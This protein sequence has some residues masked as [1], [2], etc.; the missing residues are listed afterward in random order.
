MSRNPKALA[1]TVAALLSLGACHDQ[2]TIEGTS[3]RFINVDGKRMKVNLSPTGVPNEYQLLTVRDAMVLNPDP[4]S[5]R[6]RGQQAAQRV[7]DA[8]CDTKGKSYQVLDERLVEQL[9]FYTRFRCV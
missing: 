3:S 9:N 1:A 5:E 4:Q 8:V 7:M 2:Q 6:A